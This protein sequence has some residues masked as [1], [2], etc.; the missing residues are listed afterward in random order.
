MVDAARPT[1]I[2]IH[3]AWQG[4]WAWDTIVPR[5]RAAGHEAIAVDLPG[6][7]DNPM[8]AA[9]VDL[10][11]YAAHVA[12]VIDSVSGPIV[13]VGHSSGGIAAEQ[14]CESR[15][16]RIAL[17]IY[18][19]AFLLPDGMSLIEFYASHLEPWMKGA[20]TRVTLDQTGELSSIDPVQAIDVFYH[21]ADRAQAAA[22]AAR[23]T[24]HPEGSR[25]SKLQLSDAR[26]GTVPRVYI[27]TLADRSVHLP[28]QRK[29][30][31]MTPCRQVASLDSD[32]APQLSDPDGLVAVMLALTAAHRRVVGAAEL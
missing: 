17:A 29:M 3:G 23:L 5:L 7:P 22:A 27:E 30:Q 8:A 16:D 19:A 15:P 11:V 10:A 28:L 18:L 12:G 14:A 13:V 9:E 4:G 26:F 21:K 24:P 25:R 2:L 20:V 31:A 1:F 32:H 6:H